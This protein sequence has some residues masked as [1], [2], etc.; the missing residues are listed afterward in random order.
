MAVKIITDSTSDIPKHVADHYGISIVPLKVLFGDQEYRD[1]I[2]LTN[3]EFYIKLS[4]HR[5]LPKT[6]QVN[7]G[8]FVEAFS[9]YLNNGDAVIGIFISSQLSGT[10]NSAVMAKEIL[11]ND[12]LYIIDSKSATFGLG[13]LVIEAAEMAFQGIEAEDIFKQIEVLKNQIAFYGVIDTL[14]YL[15]KGGRLSATSAIA[16][17]ILG[18]KPIIS[19]INGAVAVI[20]KAR[21][22]KRAFLWMLDH[23]KQNQ[24]DLTDKRVCIAHAASPESL[25]ELKQLI[26]DNFKTKE[27]ID[28]SLGPVIGTHTGPG[29][30]GFCCFT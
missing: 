5:E 27:I 13:H 18:I 23:L 11:N 4:Q 9:K 8:E 25:E 22:R 1:G 26:R 12:K 19:L 16:G 3:E 28:F 30:I 29:C 20:G 24:V 17:S 10:Y 6:A 2:D 21:G 15:K 7:P 14:E